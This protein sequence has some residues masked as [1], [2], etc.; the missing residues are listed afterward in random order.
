FD[1]AIVIARA[2]LLRNTYDPEGNALLNVALDTALMARHE[3]RKRLG[4]SFILKLPDEVLAIIFR[5]TINNYGV[6]RNN[7]ELVCRG[8]RQVARNMPAVW[9]AL[10]IEE[11]SYELSKEAGSYRPIFSKSVKQL[12]ETC[13]GRVADL[14]A[15]SVGGLIQWYNVYGDQSSRHLEHLTFHFHKGNIS[16]TFFMKADPISFTWQTSGYYSGYGGPRP[17]PLKSE[18][19]KLPLRLKE[20][21]ISKVIFD[22]STICARLSDLTKMSIDG[23]NLRFTQLI[24]VMK[25]SPR[26]ATLKVAMEPESEAPESVGRILLSS[27]Y[28][29]DIQ[30][31]GDVIKSITVPFLRKLAISETDEEQAFQDLRP[32]DLPL[33]SLGIKRNS[34]TTLE[35]HSL[36]PTLQS[37]SLTHWDGASTDK[38]IDRLTAGE[39]P[40]LTHL[41]VSLTHVKTESLA[42]LVKVRNPPIDQRLVQPA[43]TPQPN[44]LES[45]EVLYCEKFS[46]TFLP[47]FRV[48]VPR[49]SWAP[50]E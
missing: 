22:F 25:A 39:C 26:L 49:V 42:R 20:L 5:E 1:E 2:G 47:W 28:S 14:R 29:L 19:S 11:D 33:V 3:N 30:R 4:R 36:P 27:L 31:G 13:S 44:R 12:M 50:V 40:Q 24:L 9:T 21:T 43:V 17:F 46:A 23:F 10:I 18:D 16:Q 45:L 8:W 6:P 34:G 37:F 38:W 35:N 48:R 32:P 7:L 41:N 15:R